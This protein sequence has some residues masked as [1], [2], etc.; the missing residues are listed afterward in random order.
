[1]RNLEEPFKRGL[2]S[3][4]LKREFRP[5]VLTKEEAS[6][7][8]LEIQNPEDPLLKIIEWTVK[9]G[10]CSH[11]VRQ[12]SRWLR[13][14]EINH[15]DVYLSGAQ[16][17]LRAKSESSIGWPYHNAIVLTVSDAVGTPQKMVVDLTL[18]P[19]GLIQLDHWVNLMES[20]VPSMH[21]LEFHYP[22]IINGFAQN[23]KILS[24]RPS[25]FDSYWDESAIMLMD[26]KQCIE[27]D[28][29]KLLQ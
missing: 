17:S 16:G 4:I 19:Q 1:L 3:S 20:E 12:L 2:F 9:D 22:G 5:T 25:E 23:E 7:L 11:R 14:K 27:Q 26:R 6:K 13:S 18:H 21:P 10:G 8:F 28:L 29:P 24:I 15:E